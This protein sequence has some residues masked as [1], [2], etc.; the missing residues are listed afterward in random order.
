MRPAGS[1]SAPRRLLLRKL[2]E[3]KRLDVLKVP[4]FWAESVK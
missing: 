3:E 2:F 4:S 1:A